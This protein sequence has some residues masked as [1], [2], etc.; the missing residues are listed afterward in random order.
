MDT[1]EQY[2]KKCDCPEIQEQKPDGETECNE[3]S[4]C[5]DAATHI[6]EYGD[7]WT[8]GKTLIWLPRQDDIQA[9][10]RKYYAQKIDSKKPHDEW[11][12]K[13]AVGLGYVLKEFIAW[14]TDNRLITTESKSFEQLWL[15]FYMWEKYRKVW[16]REKWVK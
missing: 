13:G 7:Y 1:T 12:P 16:A 3:I 14:T 15:A 5:I 4:R 2:I 8:V 9:M 6:S 11:F 10:I